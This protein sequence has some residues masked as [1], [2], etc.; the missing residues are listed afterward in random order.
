MENPYS[1]ID[2]D[3]KNVIMYYHT[4]I[5][6]IG[7]YTSISLAT[8]VCSYQFIK[9]QPTLNLTDNNKLLYKFISFLVLLTSIGFLAIAAQ[10]LFTLMKDLRRLPKNYGRNQI[11]NWM[12]LP[13]LILFVHVILMIVILGLIYIHFLN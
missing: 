12:K 1:I 8:I 3:D 11:A 6:N 4:T 13:Y 5:R 2:N 10:V 9:N 7:L